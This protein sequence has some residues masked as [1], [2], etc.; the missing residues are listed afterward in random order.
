MCP[1]LSGRKTLYCTPG[2][3]LGHIAISGPASASQQTEHVI[4]NKSECGRDIVPNRP[5]FTRPCVASWRPEGLPPSRKPT[6]KTAM[7]NSHGEL[8][9]SI[10]RAVQ[11]HVGPPLHSRHRPNRPGGIIQKCCDCLYR[12]VTGASW[13]PLSPSSGHLVHNARRYGTWA[14]LCMPSPHD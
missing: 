6:Q 10:S 4:R 14:I 3:Y 5:G 9:R 8:S 11:L 7:S 2:V 1:G 12:T 13:P